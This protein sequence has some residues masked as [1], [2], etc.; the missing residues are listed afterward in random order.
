MNKLMK[1]SIFEIRHLKLEINV[2]LIIIQLSLTKNKWLNAQYEKC[3][4]K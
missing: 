4:T 1:Y 2:K 3:V